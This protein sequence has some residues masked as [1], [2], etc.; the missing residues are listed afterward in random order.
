M[1]ACSRA[2]NLH[3]EVL[4]WMQEARKLVE[5][6]IT[7]MENVEMHPDGQFSDRA[8]DLLKAF[9]QAKSFG[10]IQKFID[11]YSQD[12][13]KQ[14]VASGWKNESISLTHIINTTLDY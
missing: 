3:D 9:Q 14:F 8:H 12:I 2:I 13:I 5:H 7:E 1:H 4:R 11:D 6:E 10:N